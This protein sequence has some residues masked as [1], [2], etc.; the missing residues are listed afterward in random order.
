MESF[1][2]PSY[3][4]GAVLL[5]DHPRQI[6]SFVLDNSARKELEQ[7]KDDFLS[8]ASHE[9]KTSLTS[10]K[11][12]RQ[13]LAKQGISDAAPALSRM[14]VQGKQL[15]RLIGELLDVSKIQAGRLEYVQEP[16]DL[17]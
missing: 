17:E 14:E 13:L 4:R 6:I 8:M 7:H 3:L 9:L 10:L 11:L 1:R 5:Q 15:E 16:V 12:Q 2:S